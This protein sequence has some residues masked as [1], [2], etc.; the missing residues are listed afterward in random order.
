MEEGNRS[1]PCEKVKN[2]DQNTWLKCFL[3]KYGEL[4]K[5]YY[6]KK[7]KMFMRGENA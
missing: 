1:N 7:F 2:M 3:A 6:T 5:K 4:C